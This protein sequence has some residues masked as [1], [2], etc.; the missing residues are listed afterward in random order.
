[1]APAQDT[2]IVY[3]TDVSDEQIQ[4]DL[5]QCAFEVRQHW[6]AKYDDLPSYY[7]VR[8]IVKRKELCMRGRGYR[9]Y[10]GSETERVLDCNLPG[11]IIKAMSIQS[12]VDA[13]GTIIP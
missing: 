7:R 13:G 10:T 8:E 6:P 4:K 3:K 12:C 5:A 11:G 9:V 2:M 1:M